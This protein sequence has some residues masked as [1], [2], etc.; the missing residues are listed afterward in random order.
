MTTK[1]IHLRS[2]VYELLW[3]LRGDTNVSYLREH[4]VTI[5]DE[6]ADERGE[7]GP[8]YGKQWRSWGTAD[9]RQ[10]DQIS[11]VLQQLRTNPDSRRMLVSAWNVGELEQMALA[12]CHVLFQFYVAGGR[13]SCQLYQR[14]ADVFL[15]VPFNIASYALLTCMLAQQC[16]LTPGEFIWSGGDCHLY[17][18]HLEQADL[19]LVARPC[20]C[21]SCG[22]GAARRASVRLPVRGLR[23]HELSVPSG[24]PGAGR[25]M[26]S[27]R[28]KPG[29]G[30]RPAAARRAKTVA[31]I[32][33]RP[34][35]MRV[36]RSRVHGRGVFALRRIRKGTRII[37][38]LGDRVSH[39]EAD[40]RYENKRS[41]TITRSCSS[42]IAASVIDGG[43]NGNDARFINHS[44]DPNCESVIEDRRVFI[45]AMRTIQ[46]G[47]ELTYDYQ[48]GRDRT[49]P[50][51][52]DEIFACHCGAGTAAA[53]CSGRPGARRARDGAPGSGV[54]TPRLSGAAVIG[55]MGVVYGDIGT[56][57]LYALEASL[58]AAGA[59]TDRLAV[60]GVLS[61][62]FWSL[63]VVVTLKYVVL[64][65]RADNEG[66]GGILSL[67]ALVQR[68]LAVGNRWQRVIVMLAA[69]GAALFYCDALITPAISVLSA[70]EGL[71]NLNP[72][73]R[74]C[75]GAG[76][77]DHHHRAVRDPVSAARKG[78]PPVRPDH[79]GVVP[80]AGSERAGGA[81]EATRRCWWRSIPSLCGAAAGAA[82]RACRWRF[83]A[84]CSWR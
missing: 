44:C 10:I 39:R 72:R 37:E 84:G 63:L 21:R 83:S 30:K 45:E 25:G 79:A 3:F 1:K 13:L 71:E 23:V 24:D 50:P 8:V 6:W 55:A 61:L 81:A 29:R 5:W 59:P 56:S 62:I 38:Y 75:R 7:L 68:T 51:D 70:V 4:G 32:V 27:T 14:S 74:P 57:P 64:I 15:G 41:A 78:R 34:G 40:R 73:H 69:L 82:A 12:P 33:A 20:R 77:A 47:E 67:F 58:T 52:I 43:S 2:V 49:D 65:M 26:S 66:E 80:G 42:S 60:L 48:I 76:D 28:Q 35:M 36:R 18:N 54:K 46:P 17:L 9:G 31:R 11:N 19:Q 22:C 53:R 16:D